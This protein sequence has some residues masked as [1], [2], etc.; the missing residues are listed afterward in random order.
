MK[1]FQYNNF[2]RYYGLPVTMRNSIQSEQVEPHIHDYIEIVMVYQGRGLHIIHSAD[3]E[4]IPSAIIRGDIFTILPGEVHSFSHCCDCRLYNICIKHEVLDE[5]HEHLTGLQYF[6]AFFNPDREF[7]VN[8]LHLSPHEFENAEMILRA[9]QPCITS[10]RSSRDFALRVKLL[11]FLLTV[12]DGDIKGFKNASSV[13]HERLFQSI[14]KLEAHPEQK[15]EV[16]RAA[17]E[18]GMSV[19]GYA[20]KFKELVGLPPGEYALRLKL[21]KAKQMLVEGELSLEE[22][23]MQCALY[24]GNYV[25]RAFKKRFGITPGRYRAV[26]RGRKA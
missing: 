18:T 3:G 11:D 23:A 7:R 14:A 5:F 22:I 21:E 15:W 8:Q 12:F 1:I 17:H 10:T 6:D 20:H 25:I 24:D 16:A 19:S 9:L 13:I 4:S 26:F 2:K